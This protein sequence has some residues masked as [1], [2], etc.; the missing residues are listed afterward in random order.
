MEQLHHSGV[1]V[2]PK[3]KGQGLS[4][5]IRGETIALTEER[6]MAWAKKIGT[7]YVDDPVFAENLHEDFSEIL[8]IKVLPGD[9]DYSEIL[10]VV[11][12]ER[13]WRA[14]L[15]QEERKALAAERN[16]VREANKEKYGWTTV[17]G[18]RHAGST[19]PLNV[20]EEE[21]YLGA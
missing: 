15:S 18:I 4:V 6:A 7:P 12:D 8:G 11:L 20:P 13:E 17:D 19:P 10:E 5:K 3:Y 14:N 2:P 9:V 16:A 1:I 21:D